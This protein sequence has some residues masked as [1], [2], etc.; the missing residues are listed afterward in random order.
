MAPATTHVS[1]V[2]ANYHQ[3]TTT[4]N[5]K[6]QYLSPTSM[7]PRSQTWNHD[8]MSV[9]SYTVDTDNA[10]TR[11]T[12]RS[13]Q[14]APVNYSNYSASPSSTGNEHTSP[15]LAKNVSVPTSP[16]YQHGF[17]QRPYAR[18]P[19][20]DNGSPVVSRRSQTHQ[21]H[22]NIPSIVTNG[23][24]YR[25]YAASDPGNR[26]DLNMQASRPRLD[27]IPEVDSHSLHYFIKDTVGTGVFVGQGSRL[28]AEH[29][30]HGG[31]WDGPAHSNAGNSMP[32]AATR[33][34]PA[35][36]V[37]GGD[38]YDEN[39]APITP[40]TSY[41]E[42]Q[43][44]EIQRQKT[45]QWEARSLF[46]E[47]GPYFSPATTTG[48]FFPNALAYVNPS[49]VNPAAVNSQLAFAAFNDEDPSLSPRQINRDYV[50]RGQ[51]VVPSDVRSSSMRPNS[52]ESNYRRDGG[53]SATRPDN[54]V[55]QSSLGKRARDEPAIISTD[56]YRR[57]VPPTPRQNN[58]R[59]RSECKRP[60]HC[61]FA[62]AGCQQTFASK[63]EWK[64]HS[65][66]QHTQAFFWRCDYPSCIERK[67]ATFNRKDLFGQH[68]KRMH[69]PKPTTTTNTGSKSGQKDKQSPEMTHFINNEVPKIQERCKRIRRELPT[70][71]TCGFC[72]H[73]FKGPNSWEERMEHVGRHYEN[74][75]ATQ[76]DVSQNAWKQDQELIDWALDCGII[77]DN[78]RGGYACLS[79]G[80]EAIVE[81]WQNAKI[82]EPHGNPHSRDRRQ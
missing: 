9:K 16:M 23:P 4:S 15:T 46:P 48:E 25:S 31:K 42:F 54:Y 55:L 33:T 62:F 35:E 30:Q 50:P 52:Y 6:S 79:T 39:G 26:N 32:F 14:P 18:Y 56:K 66:S 22:L 51:E 13:P 44:P 81:A 45:P 65:N 21:S 60:F 63:N 70:S 20:S 24:E 64:R 61:D 74:A 71:S 58:H 7:H 41:C 76:E 59:Y 68:L 37:E 28:S 38:V 29:V 47:L 43:S 80:K 69:G 19:K 77:I 82:Y 73:R 34:S 36:S 12:T 5:S 78:G 27:G 2:N 49:T 11:Q 67:T 75:I 17:T 1:I 3:G 8:D 53:D 57:T 40:V 72:S 10:S